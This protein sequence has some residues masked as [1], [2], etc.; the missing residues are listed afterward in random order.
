MSDVKTHWD[1]VYRSRAPEQVSWYQAHP[2]RSAA[3]IERAAESAGTGIIDVGGGA[4]TLVD[5]LIARGYEDLTVLDVSG[6]AITRAKR[7]LGERAARVTWIEADV[8]RFEPMRT[9]D[10][11]HDRAVFHFLIDA[12]SRAAYRAALYTALRPG[13]QI[14]IAT[15]G[16]HGPQRCSGL[17][18]RRYEPQ[19]LHA[20][21]GAGL[22]L[23]ESSTELHLTPAGAEQQFVYCRF[24]RSK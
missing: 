24:R 2:Q 19:A 17:E 11:W 22:E 4:S 1:S 7:R 23:L 21:L 3:M 20:E 9:W 14:V 8:T 16:P 18:V 12:P 10:V 6:E 13:G 15:F 5:F